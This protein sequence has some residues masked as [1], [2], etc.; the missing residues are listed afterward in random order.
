M[1][2][3][4]LGG[5]AVVRSV[6]R[7]DLVL[8]DVAVMPLVVARLPQPAAVRLPLAD[9]VVRPTRLPFPSPSVKRY[10]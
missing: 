6:Q 8:P 2:D 7:P 4:Y 5:R 3:E 10:Q 1:G 9:V